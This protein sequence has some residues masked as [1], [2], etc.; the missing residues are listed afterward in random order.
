MTAQVKQL[1]PPEVVQV[2]MAEIQQA[3]IDGAYAAS[4]VL[5][6]DETGMIF[7]V[8]PKYQYV[9]AD[10]Q[11]ASAPESDDK[12]RFTTFVLGN[13]QGDKNPIDLSGTR[14]IANLHSEPGFRVTDGWVL[15]VWQKD[16]RLSDEKRVEQKRRT[17]GDRT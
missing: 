6:G 11:R 8:Q 7:G 13:A 14:V 12:S 3:I 2:R 5:N 1:P 15:K 4:D 9:S 17:G 10:A 16:V